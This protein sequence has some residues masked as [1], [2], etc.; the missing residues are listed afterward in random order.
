M[1]LKIRE[2][3]LRV[4]PDG[5][6]IGRDTIITSKTKND[7]FDKPPMYPVDLFAG[8]AA[9]LDTAGAYSL[10]VACVDGKSAPNGCIPIL[11]ADRKQFELIGDQWSTSPRTPEWVTKQWKE[12]VKHFDE[13][14]SPS[15]T[16]RSAAKWI[17][18]AFGLLA[19]ADNACRDVGTPPDKNASNQ[20]WVK[21]LAIALG[22]AVPSK[23]PKNGNIQFQL[24][25][26]SITSSF[27]DDDVVCVLP[28]ARTPSVGCSFRNISQNLAMLPPKSKLSASWLPSFM[29]PSPT[30]ENK[31]NLL[32]IP[33]PFEIQDEDFEVS[34]VSDKFGCNAW[35]WFDLKQKWL[36]KPL[37]LVE[38]VRRLI[39]CAQNKRPKIDI[40]G[41]LFPEYALDYDVYSAIESMLRDEYPDLQFFVSGSRTNCAKQAGNYAMATH[42][43]EG[44]HEGKSERM[45]MTTSQ[46]K[47][48]RWAMTHGQIKQY[49]LEKAFPESVEGNTWWEHIPLRQ[50]E[51]HM[52]PLPSG[53]IFSIM[54]CESCS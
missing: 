51:M 22:L 48:H 5:T 42:F 6:D 20:N 11:P 29:P 23:K 46:P 39:Q 28:K 26:S 3:L 40:D 27:V 50:R 12:L 54:V 2:F 15:N 16:K 41:I 24:Q 17:P 34:V 8:M 9:L 44:R 35:G 36:P 14:I 1:S 4:Y 30:K 38:L 21:T 33:F 43:N 31:L 13:T 37:D 25:V 32:L 53:S 18:I 47:H 49:G 10:I 52:H 45:M 7:I 19:V